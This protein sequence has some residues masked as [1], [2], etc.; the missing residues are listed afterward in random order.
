[1]VQSGHRFSLPFV[2][3]ESL[4]IAAAISVLLVS[5]LYISNNVEKTA[6]CIGDEQDRCSSGAAGEPHPVR[7]DECRLNACSEMTYPASFSE[8]I[9]RVS[10]KGEAYFDVSKDVEHPF[11]VQTKKCDIKVLGTEFNVRVNEA[12]SDCEFSAACWEGSIELT[13]KM[14]PGRFHPACCDAE[15]GMD[16]RGKNGGGIDP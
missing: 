4:K 5:A 16:G 15:S 10:L 11:V 1:M 13:N 7:W 2:I 12:E 3:R 9:R 8:D 6:P 14:E